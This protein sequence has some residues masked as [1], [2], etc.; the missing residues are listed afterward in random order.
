MKR[1]VVTLGIVLAVL[2][3]IFCLYSALSFHLLQ[4]I[5]S[6]EQLPRVRYDRNCWL[7]FFFVAMLAAYLLGRL[8]VWVTEG[9]YEREARTRTPALPS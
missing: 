6:P 8:W 3:A 9:V 5:S 2:F 4:D 7:V 1:S